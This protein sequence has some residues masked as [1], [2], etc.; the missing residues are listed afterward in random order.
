MSWEKWRP[1][2]PAPPGILP[3]PHFIPSYKPRLIFPHENSVF[4]F[5]NLFILQHLREKGHRH[6]SSETNSGCGPDAGTVTLL[7]DQGEL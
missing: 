6:H 5:S 4:P 2:L 7:T 1:F 3:A